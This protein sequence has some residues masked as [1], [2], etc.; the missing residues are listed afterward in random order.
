VKPAIAGKYDMAA[1]LVTQIEAVLITLVWSGLVSAV[2]FF[3]L[4]KTM[5]MRPSVEVEHEGL[6]I[7]EHGER[8]YNY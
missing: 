6:D 1:Q 2:L 7:N 5:G 3:L 8:A 4:D